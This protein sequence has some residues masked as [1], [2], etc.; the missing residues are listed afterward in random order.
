MRFINFF[1][2]SEAVPTGLRSRLLRHMGVGLGERTYVASRVMLKSKSVTTG[3]G[4][5][6]NHGVHFDRGLVALGDHVFIGPGA[7]FISNDHELGGPTC[8]AGRNVERPIAVG[9]GAWIGSRVIVLGGVS[10]APGCIIAAGAVVT[11]S[12]EA[13]GVYAGIPARR[14]KDL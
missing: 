5:F 10:I 12:T 4:C 14:I 1:V 3:R 11:K 13:N 8:R 7:M 9:D 6:I 2:M